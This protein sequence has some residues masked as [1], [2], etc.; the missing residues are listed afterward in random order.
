MKR[1]MNKL[2]A[3]GKN[4]R[5]NNSEG[6][7]EPLINDASSGIL[8]RRLTNDA[9]VHTAESPVTSAAPAADPAEATAEAPAPIQEEEQLP[10]N[11]LHNRQQTLPD[12]SNLWNRRQSDL[13]YK[14]SG[15]SRSAIRYPKVK[16]HTIRVPPT[17]EILTK[18]LP[19]R[20]LL[21]ETTPAE[22]TIGIP[23]EPASSAHAESTDAVKD[24]FPS[25]SDTISSTSP[26]T[27]VER[28]GATNAKLGARESELM[29][30]PV[31]NDRV[32]STTKPGAVA[33]SGMPGSLSRTEKTNESHQKAP[34]GAAHGLVAAGTASM[35]RTATG[36][37]ATVSSLGHTDTSNSAEA[38]ASLDSSASGTG[39]KLA[40]NPTTS[41]S[42]G[43]AS[44]NQSTNS[45]PSGSVQA[46]ASHASSSYRDSI[47]NS[48]TF[49]G[50][51]AKNSLL[52]D[53]EDDEIA[54]RPLQ[55]V[56]STAPFTVESNGQLPI[57][58]RKSQ[59]ATLEDDSVDNR[60]LAFAEGGSN[61]FGSKLAARSTLNNESPTKETADTVDAASV[62]SAVALVAARFGQSAIEADS[63]TGHE[64]HLSEQEQLETAL[65]ESKMQLEHE[66]ERP[67]TL[68]TEKDIEDAKENARSVRSMIA[69]DDV[70]VGFLQTVLELCRADQKKVARG[71]EDVMNHK[72]DEEID[73]EVLID[74]NINLLDVIEMGARIAVEDSKP[75][76]SKK[77]VAGNLDVDALIQKKDIFS[78]ICMLR[79][80]Q[81]E[82]R[83]DAALALMKFARGSDGVDSE[84]KISLRDEIRS[85][86]GLHSLLTLFRT[87]LILYELKVVTALAVAYVLPSF[88]ESSTQSPP[89]LAL[90]IVECLRFLATAQA[91]SRKY[92]VIAEDEMLQAC[93]AALASFW[94]H[95]LEP[96]LKSKQSTSLESEPLRRS[97][98]QGRQRGRGGDQRQEAMALDEL[99]EMTISLI[100]QMSK[101][102]LSENQERDRDRPLKW[103]YTLV[104]QVCAVEIARPIAVREGILQIL[105][106]WISSKDIEK[107]RPAVSALR[108][109][110]SIDDK[111]MAGWIHSEMVNKGAVKCLADLTRD[112]SV[113]RDIRLYVAQILSSLCAAPHTRAAIVEANCINFLIGILYE[114]SDPASEE[115]AL[116]AGRAILQLAA[117]AITRASAFNGDDLDVGGYVTPNKRDALVG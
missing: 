76:P 94:V 1:L 35:Q 20:R 12:L 60:Q 50:N 59:S 81:N 25:S 62:D 113:T 88:V 87:P 36:D 4:A 117:G 53:E 55:M 83:L 43:A 11:E 109:V 105:V 48:A 9:D 97:V 66:T 73:L 26:P 30:P 34:D 102:D 28:S 98:S 32:V 2:G 19:Y 27:D 39:R 31:L 56:G 96:M 15:K 47:S 52:D 85:S 65:L 23:V 95:L 40:A 54:P 111:Y 44:E 115:I 22:A 57:W 110:T 99:L 64:T 63:S 108:Y 33:I 18:D 41:L 92:D 68:L 80:Q 112:I 16:E 84:A 7:L 42:V 17:E 72:G 82:K 103:S 104:E 61:G 71:I 24:P 93:N 75:A 38:R 90:K 107:I 70:D 114:H 74:L 14:S 77:T 116:F 79:V 58:G 6:N 100:I 5:A 46:N 8:R 78:L 106:S 21:R 67:V 45:C 29:P 49:G 37:S 3:G 10:P 101:Q 86:G 91:V 69:S 13:G 89:S 51:V